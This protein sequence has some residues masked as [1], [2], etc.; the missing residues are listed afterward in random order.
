LPDSLSP[1]SG[2]EL[3]GVSV[4]GAFLDELRFPEYRAG[5]FVRYGTLR[6]A[7]FDNSPPERKHSSVI[8]GFALAGMFG[9]S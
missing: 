2:K 8:A 7:V 4:F 3:A 9:E 1:I 5:G 6:N